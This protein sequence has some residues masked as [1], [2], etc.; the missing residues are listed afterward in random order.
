LRFETSAAD[1]H[2]VDLFMALEES[3]EAQWRALRAKVRNQDPE[4]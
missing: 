4:S 1:Q 2:R 3:E